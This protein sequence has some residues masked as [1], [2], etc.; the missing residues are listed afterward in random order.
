MHVW[1]DQFSLSVMC[2]PRNL[3]LTTLSTIVPSMWIEIQ[4]SRGL[5]RVPK[6]RTD[7]GRCT[8]LHI[9]MTAWNSIPHQVTHAS[10]KIRLKK[11][12]KNTPYGPAGNVKQHKHRHGHMHTHINYYI[13]SIH[14][15]THGFCVV[16]M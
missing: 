11:T 8:T 2:T 15:S 13:R 4:R 3:K 1:V 7:Y 14:T 5:F 12:D 6:S 16:D 10:S 9:A